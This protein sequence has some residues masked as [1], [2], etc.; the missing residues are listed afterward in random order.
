MNRIRKG[1]KLRPPV[2]PFFVEKQLSDKSQGNLISPIIRLTF[3]K[4]EH[5]TYTYFSAL[6]PFRVISLFYLLSK[7]GFTQ[8][9]CKYETKEIFEWLCQKRKKPFIYLFSPT[10]NSITITSKNLINCMISKNHTF[11]KNLQGCRFETPTIEI[12]FQANNFIT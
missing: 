6:A 2:K 7:T 8:T 9:I 12:E 1:K 4:M 10:L 3:T 11:A 5:H